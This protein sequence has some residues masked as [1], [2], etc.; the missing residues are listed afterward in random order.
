[1]S[2]RPQL[3]PRLKQCT[4]CKQV[5]SLDQFYRDPRYANKLKAACKV[6]CTIQG[7]AWQR[8]HPESNRMAVKRWQERNVEYRRAYQR[9]YSK[10]HRETVL[11][12]ERRHAIL[13]PEKVQA[14]SAAR[15]SARNKKI[16]RQPCVICGATNVEA[17]HEDYS[18]PL[19]VIWLC[20]KHH[21]EA[22]ERLRKRIAL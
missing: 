16:E 13:H 20:K 15:H 18:K 10:E 12:K 2:E 19:N 4:K 7:Q 1:M 21:F 9:K 3:L 22:D 5:K 14:R 11:A 17:H 8:K 6:C